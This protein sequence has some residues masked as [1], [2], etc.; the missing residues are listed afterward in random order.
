MPRVFCIVQRAGF[1]PHWL[2]VVSLNHH[3]AIFTTSGLLYH[4]S[5]SVKSAEMLYLIQFGNTLAYHSDF[6]GR[7]LRELATTRGSANYKYTYML[8][9]VCIGYVS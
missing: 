2:G 9:E 8:C 4:H 7:I 5:Q 1:C 3:S 6:L